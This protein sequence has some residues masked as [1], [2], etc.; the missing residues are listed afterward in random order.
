MIDWLNLAANALWIVGLA[1]ALATM[2]LASWQAQ[3]TKEKLRTRLAQPAMQTALSLAGALFCI[4]QAGASQ[5][6]LLIVL[7]AVLGMAFL[8]QVIWSLFHRQHLA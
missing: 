2:S 6:I 8:A 4:G 3:R 7:W 1:L 5:G